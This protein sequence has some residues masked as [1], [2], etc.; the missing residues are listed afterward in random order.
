MLGV[1]SP[2]SCTQCS[3]ACLA[4]RHVEKFREVTPSDPKVITAMTLNFKPIFEFSL[5]LTTILNNLLRIV[6]GTPVP[7]EVSFSKPLPLPSVC[8]HLRQQH[9]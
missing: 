5:L 2:K 7:D 9:R 3:H 6:G 1:R 4:A 8:K